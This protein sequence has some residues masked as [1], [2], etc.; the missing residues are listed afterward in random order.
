MFV[1]DLAHIFVEKAVQSG[2]QQVQT[3][4]SGD[5]DG[6][7]GLLPF[8]EKS[9]FVV[10]TFRVSRIY[11][12]RF[13]GF[14]FCLQTFKQR[15]SARVEIGNKFHPLIQEVREIQLFRVA[16]AVKLVVPWWLIICNTVR[17]T[18][19]RKLDAGLREISSL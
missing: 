18:A 1:A 19:G 5:G 11:V 3:C 17:N 10:G 2:L 8:L 15:R 4:R 14:D 13:P 9:G 7:I 16:A 12:G 6:L